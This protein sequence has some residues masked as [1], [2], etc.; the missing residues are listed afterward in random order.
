LLPRESLRSLRDGADAD[1]VARGNYMPAQSPQPIGIDAMEKL[2]NLTGGE[3]FVNTNDLTGAIQKAVEDSTVIYTL[4]F[5]IEPESID[6]KVHD[7]KVRVKGKGLTVRYPK[8]YLAFKDVP[9][10]KDAIHNSLVAAVRSPVESSAIPLVARVERVNQPAPDT[11]QIT[12]VLDPHHVQLEQAGDLREGAV[13]ITIVEQDA[14]GKV[15]GESLD[16]INLQLT[17]EKYAEALKIGVQFEK[18]V[19]A[20]AGATTLR[21]LV[22]DPATAQVGSLIIPLAKIQ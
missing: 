13:D 14:T 16:R 15:L 3:A 19:A 18:H 4:G 7:L 17:P 10:T 8:G 20:Q 12:G 22:E 6:G 5:Y 21:I 2:A 11:L 1:A 9:T